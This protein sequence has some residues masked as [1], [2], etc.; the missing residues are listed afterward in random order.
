MTPG[1]R[2]R[3]S[4]R[5]L[6]AHPP[7]SAK[8]LSTVLGYD[9]NLLAELSPEHQRSLDGLTQAWLVA[10]VVMAFPMGVAMWLVE[11][12]LPLAVFVSAGTYVLIVNLL[13]L[14][15][16]G[17]GTAPEH[18]L[19][20]EYRPSI[21]PTVLLMGLATIMSQPAQLLH[22]PEAVRAQVESHRAALIQSHL[23]AQAAL[24]IEQDQ[25]LHDD[26]FLRQLERCEF[27]VLRLKLLW[28]SPETTV[29]WTL[30]FV[31]AALF[32]A[33]LAR[34]V[35][36][37]AVMAYERARYRRERRAVRRSSRRTAR[38]IERELSRFPTH[39]K[40]WP[41]PPSA[42]LD[43]SRLALVSAQQETGS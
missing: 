29:L 27:V 30:L 1:G 41:L 24:S 26:A 34:V 33:A 2:S 35:W 12:S 20:R 17:S 22:T 40:P 8:P 18:R 36:L 15:T 37:P 32:P 19:R 13:R 6:W 28:T 3:A 31:G 21:L 10:C 43:G 39:R 9:P 11:H 7:D 38:A 14:V 25:A 42:P 5:E 16:A 4:G 23:E